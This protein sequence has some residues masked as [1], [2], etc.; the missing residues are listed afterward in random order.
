VS[1]PTPTVFVVDD[2][3]AFLDSLRW[4][5]QSE[6]YGVDTHLSAEAFLAVCDPHHCGCLVLDVQMPSMGGLTLQDELLQR[7]IHLPIIF[8]TGYGEIAMA[9]GA[10]KK[11]AFDFIEKPFDGAAFLAVVEKAVHYDLE[12]RRTRARRLSAAAC[13]SK[14]S[15]RERDVFE[16][17]VTGKP[18]KII[19]DELGISVKT[20]EAHRARMMM[21]MGAESIAQLVQLANDGNHAN[22]H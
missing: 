16:R 20:V 21:K 18:N 17:A 7:G 1:T 2:D 6:G 11:G 19:A 15:P 5:L 9:V 4:I 14:L 8:V 22:A 12:S 13:I 10:L 3:A